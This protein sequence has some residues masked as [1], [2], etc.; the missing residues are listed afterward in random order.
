PIQSGQAMVFAIALTLI[1]SVMI[2]FVIN[3]GRAVNEKINLVNAADA[4]AYSGAQ[5][6]AR[7]LNFMAYT[8]RAMIANEVAIGHSLS[9]HME[10][11]LARQVAGAVNDVF[12]GFQAIA[13][14]VVGISDILG[15]IYML[16]VDANNAYYSRQQQLA[17]SNFAA[18]VNG[19]TVLEGA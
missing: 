14:L 8:N 2:F 10:V 7:Q 9:F 11:D 16:A 17:F 5:I 19:I 6:T 1:C 15:G 13:D 4:A 12:P 3:S 18:P